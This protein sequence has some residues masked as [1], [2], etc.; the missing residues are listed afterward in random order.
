MRLHLIHRAHPE[1][2]TVTFGRIMNAVFTRCLRWRPGYR[3]RDV[4][5]VEV[6]GDPVR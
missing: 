4:G 2:P 5:L 6:L 3:H 1:C